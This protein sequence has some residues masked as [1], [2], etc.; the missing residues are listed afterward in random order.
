MSDVDIDELFDAAEAAAVSAEP[1][2]LANEQ[3]VKQRLA[4]DHPVIPPAPDSVVTLPR[5]YIENGTPLTEVEIRE[6]NGADEERL[7]RYK[8]EEDVYNAIITMCTVRVGSIDLKGEPLS[9]RARVLDSLLTG[10]RELIFLKIL[11]ATFGNE[12][13]YGFICGNCEEQ[14][15]VTILLDEDLP[16]ILP[17]DDLEYTYTYTT[18]RGTAIEYRL[19]VG[20]DLEGLA[21]VTNIAART[22]HLLSRVILK[23]NGES[24]MDKKAVAQN[25]NSGDRAGLEADIRKNSPYIKMALETECASCGK[26]QTI[27]LQWG[28]FLSA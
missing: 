22:T 7:A 20:A 9:A 1:I 8:T 11:G 5:G 12:K 3:A 15:M 26:E 21:G 6:L 24:P 10:E 13:E 25:L 16:L 27:P 23:V 18:K 17:E 14:N 19:P 2:D 28:Q 4:G